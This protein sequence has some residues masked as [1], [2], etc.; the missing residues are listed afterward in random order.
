MTKLID[1]LNKMNKVGNFAVMSADV[2]VQ[3]VY[4]TLA[5]KDGMP[6]DMKISKTVEEALKAHDGFLVAAEIMTALIPEMGD[7]PAYDPADL[8]PPGFVLN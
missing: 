7:V 8:P 2:P 6:F 1:T 5:L 4:L 3:G